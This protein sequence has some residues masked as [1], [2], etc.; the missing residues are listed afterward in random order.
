MTQA[1]PSRFRARHAQLLSCLAFNVG[2]FI[3]LCPLVESG[4]LRKAEVV[5]LYPPRYPHALFRQYQLRLVFCETHHHISFCSN[6]RETW[7]RSSAEHFPKLWKAT[8]S[9]NPK[10]VTNLGKVG[11][12]VWAGW[13]TK[14]ILH[15]GLIPARLAGHVLWNIHNYLP[16]WAQ[17][18]FR[19]RV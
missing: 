17:N 16:F 11:V 10:L 7:G 13:T 18:C 6:S 14:L 1:L 5:F 4:L 12:C 9:T 2:V 3:S 19:N 8:L 15:R